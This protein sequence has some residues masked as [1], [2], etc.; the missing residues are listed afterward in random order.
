MPQIGVNIRTMPTTKGYIIKAIP[1]GA[2]VNNY[3][4]YGMDEKGD[5][6]LYTKYGNIIGYIKREFL[7]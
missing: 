1:K 4:Y 2:K 7:S 3:G 6:W 5:V